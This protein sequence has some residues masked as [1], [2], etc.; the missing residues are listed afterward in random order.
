MP[1][2]TATPLPRPD[3]IPFPDDLK[4][5][6]ADYLRQIAKLRDDDSPQPVD[7]FLLTRDQARAFY[8]NGESTPTATPEGATPQ[9]TATPSGPDP[10]DAHQA[11]YELLGLVP[12]KEQTGQTVQ[13]QQTN[14]LIS[15]ITGF[16]SPPYHAFYMIE[17]I[18]G[19]IY[20]PLAK[21]TIV[22]ELTHALQYQEV[23]VNKIAA[24]RAGS[25]DATTALLDVLEGDAVHTEI[26]LLGY[27]TRS[28]YRQ[29][30][31]FT[32]PAPQRPG[33]PYVVERELD[34][35]YEDGLCFIQ[36]IADKEGPTGIADVFK[37]LPT[38]TEQ[39]LHP[40]KYLAGEKG[41]PVTLAPLANTLG[42]SWR[43]LDQGDFGEFGLQNILLVGLP[44]DRAAVQTAAAGWNGD[45][46]DL[47]V[48]G[49]DRLFHL[50][51]LW[52]TPNDA[53]EFYDTLSRSL[54]VRAGAGTPTT[55]EGTYSISIGPASWRLSLQSDRVSVLVATSAA[56][57]DA[58]A[59]ALGLP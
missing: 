10:I 33:T 6:A 18:N 39:I 17:T 34:T 58:A 20:G 8:S 26:A 55:G 16:Y 57:V 35:W 45:A 59:K 12:P 43:R 3:A 40:E 38:T 41:M 56:P 32:I 9:P 15:I 19:G 53:R 47:Y 28:T 52:D 21:S 42:P 11:L 27:S 2:P 31:C 7:M 14:N 46:W 29:P 50:D 49:G 24:Q 48:S 30:V 5:Q 25:F 44:G 1:E 4:A 13:Q 36:T 54:A 23:D 22:H 51:T 37:N